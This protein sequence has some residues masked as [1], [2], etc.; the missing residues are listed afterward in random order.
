MG[1][2]HLEK[3]NGTNERLL[4]ALEP[5]SDHLFRECVDTSLM[6]TTSRWTY[7]V[8][9][10]ASEAG[11][12][13]HAKYDREISDQATLI[14]ESLFEV[15][16]SQNTAEV[17]L[18]TVKH[19]QVH[20]YLPYFTEMATDMQYEPAKLSTLNSIIVQLNRCF[21]NGVTLERD[22]LFYMA[23]IYLRV[24]SRYVDWESI[25]SRSVKQGILLLLRQYRQNMDPRKSA[26][27]QKRL[28][29]PDFTDDEWWAFL[30]F[31]DIQSDNNAAGQT[32]GHHMDNPEG[33]ALGDA[34][35]QTTILPDSPI[36]N[37]TDGSESSSHPV[38]LANEQSGIGAQPPL[39]PQMITDDEIDRPARRRD[40]PPKE[41]DY[42]IPEPPDIV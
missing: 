11:L 14:L 30:D 33:Y 10:W 9:R 19:F 35:R 8:P 7:L 41:D 32:S 36:S 13:A 34:P 12:V 15:A 3:L 4:H 20:P 5:N 17:E 24:Y 18:D 39:G 40:L 16:G 37:I 26:A 25:L 22:L 42:S 27:L 21:S 23:A 2:C 28:G 1:Q 38:Q 31:P 29:I 6:Q